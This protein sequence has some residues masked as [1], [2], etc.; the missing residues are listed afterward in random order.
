LITE[1][2]IG[3]G[4]FLVEV[5]AIATSMHAVLHARTAQGATAWAIALVSF[6][7]LSL[8][9]YAAFGR[10]KFEGYVA[11]RAADDREVLPVLDRIIERN[12]RELVARLE[13]EEAAF[14]A[15]EKL[16]QMPFTRGNQARLLAPRRQATFDAILAAV[17]A[18][19]D[20]VLVQ[21]YIIR[22]DGL[23]RALK[24]RLREGIRVYLLYD[25]IGSYA[26]PER[27]AAEL[28]A[29]GQERV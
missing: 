1:W 9:L 15:L 18:A 24:T 11:A 4:Y 8:P 19:R 3:I 25:E 7:L 26:L 17:D 12:P 6:P 2:G 16:A 5:A 21:F 20:Y 29:A 22:D 23:G 28:R 13:G 14:K 10:S 27:Y